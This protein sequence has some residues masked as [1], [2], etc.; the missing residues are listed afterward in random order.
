MKRQHL[1]GGPIKNR[2]LR[3]IT[4][5]LL[6]LYEIRKTH[7]LPTFVAKANATIPAT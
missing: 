6:T 3:A 2:L 5:D 7:A 1:K 4:K